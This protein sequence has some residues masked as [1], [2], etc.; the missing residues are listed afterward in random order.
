M[1]AL[2]A[3]C[4]AAQSP[5]APA[6]ARAVGASWMR[7][8]PPGVPLLYVSDIGTNDVYV[9]DYPSLLAYGT[10]TGFDKPEGLCTDSA[11]HVFITNLGAGTVK[12]FDHGGTITIN[13]FSPGGTPMGCAVEPVTNDLAVADSSTGK[14]TLYHDEN[15][16]LPTVYGP[17]AFTSMYYLAYDNSHNLYMDGF[18]GAAFEYEHNHNNGAFVPVAYSGPAI[19]NPGAIQWSGVA[20]K[21][22][23]GDQNTGNLYEININ[24]TQFGATV[25]LS[26]AVC[27]GQFIIRGNKVVAPDRCSSDADVYHFPSGLF[28]VGVGITA[29]F[30]STISLP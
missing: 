15:T 17:G 14:Y 8:L 27:I 13:T 3:A 24:G 20:H 22:W 28:D 6:P 16:T 5:V 19:A 26:G 18:D 4:Q 25:T 30:G 23:I 1:I 2:L 21:V 29:P 9:F 12:E 11:G 10:L 7:A